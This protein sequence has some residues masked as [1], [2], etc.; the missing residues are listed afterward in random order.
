MLF[1]GSEGECGV[2]TRVTLE[3]SEVNT[4]RSHVFFG[5]HSR[6][7]LPLVRHTPGA[8]QNVCN[9]HELARQGRMCR[10]QL[11]ARTFSLFVGVEGSMRAYAKQKNCMPHQQLAKPLTIEIVQ[12]RHTFCEV[13]PR[14]FCRLR[15]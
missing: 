6:Q 11:S 14:C 13:C 12:K 15:R 4:R 1:L 8:H 9:L 3:L 5:V 2:T 10:T 7:K